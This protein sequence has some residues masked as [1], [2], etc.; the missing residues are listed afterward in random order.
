MSKLTL[1]NISRLC[2][3]QFVE[4]NK[5][6]VSRVDHRNVLEM[7]GEL[8]SF[9]VVEKPIIECRQFYDDCVGVICYNIKTNKTYLVDSKSLYVYKSPNRITTTGIKAFSAKAEQNSKFEIQMTI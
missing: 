1:N 6:K 8:Y 4:K 7:N 2:F 5:N 3:A 9:S